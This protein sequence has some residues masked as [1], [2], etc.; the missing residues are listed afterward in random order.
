[1]ADAQPIPRD[2]LEAYRHLYLTARSLVELAEPVGDE[3]IINTDNLDDLGA[4]LTDI[5]RITQNPV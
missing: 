2:E 3:T 4:A 5:Y 1:M